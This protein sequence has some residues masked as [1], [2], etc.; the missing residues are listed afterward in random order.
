LPDSTTTL[1][2]IP[3]AVFWEEGMLLS[4]QHFQQAAQRQEE[5]L[6]YHLGLDTPYHWGVVNV[7]WDEAE[8]PGG[9]LRARELEAVMPDGL[10]VRHHAEQTLELDL[11]PL[12]EAARTAPVRIWLTV[13]ARRD[14]GELVKGA[15]PRTARTDGDRV[16]DDFTGEEIVIRRAR[17]VLGLQ[18]GKRPENT[19]VSL[20][21][22]E[23]RFSQEAFELAPFVPPLLRCPKGSKPY[24]WCSLHARRTRNRAAELAQRGLPT[25]A[26]YL[27]IRAMAGALPPFEA[28]INS[29]RAHP[30]TLY[31]A[32]CAFAGWL[33]G[34]IPGKVPP[35]FPPYDHE[36]L[37]RSFAPLQAFVTEILEG[38]AET[39]KRESFERHG[40]GFRLPLLKR[41]WVRPEGLVVGWMKGA[42]I[43]SQTQYDGLRTARYTGAARERVK[44]PTPLGMVAR[45]GEVLFTVK[46]GE[47][48]TV[49]QPLMM[50]NPEDP[51][52]DRRPAEAI[53]YTV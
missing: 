42:K 36:D 34:A 7:V 44:D 43:A 37:G 10:A 22:A 50:V 25:D 2:H 11:E 4:P 38:M 39:R 52:G 33:A 9:R 23:V 18:A 30:F 8:L 15:T 51:A 1:H 53:L 6:H 40:G 27:S 49:E 21:V 17:P 26:V 20:P 48:V 13:P 5:L 19:H 16:P 3:E 35:A 41:E 45:K 29:A 47:H 46:I 28:V 31:H 24:E 14:P 12:T 32:F